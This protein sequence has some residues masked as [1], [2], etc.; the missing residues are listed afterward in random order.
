MSKKCEHCGKGPLYGNNVS[1]SQVKTRMR[2]MPNLHTHNLEING[3]KNKYKLC[4]KCL[5]TLIKKELVLN[6]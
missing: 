1:H 4:T 3:K 6:A 2:Q 5:K